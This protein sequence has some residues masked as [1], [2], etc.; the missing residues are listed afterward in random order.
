[1]TKA[2]TKP[3]NTILKLL[4][5]LERPDL[6]IVEARLSELL[7]GDGKKR[8]V[9]KLMK[10]SF[11]MNNKTHDLSDSANG[12]ARQVARILYPQLEN[13]KFNPVRVFTGRETANYW[14]KSEFNKIISAIEEAGGEV[15]RLPEGVE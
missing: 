7:N 4:P 14:Q 3:L 12:I 15:I 10:F 8:S 13:V 6:A 2:K 1:M 11:K 9:K 5:D